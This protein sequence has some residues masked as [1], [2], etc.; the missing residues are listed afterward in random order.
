MKNTNY[1]RTFTYYGKE[2]TLWS[3]KEDLEL[4]ELRR[5]GAEIDEVAEQLERTP[6][7]IKNRVNNRHFYK[8][9]TDTYKKG[10]NNFLDL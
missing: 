1:K 8:T 2:V 6:K 5:A 10:Y 7:A 4:I 3:K 9:Y